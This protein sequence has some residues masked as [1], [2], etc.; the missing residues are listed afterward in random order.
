MSGVDELIEEL[1]S[2]D[3]EARAGA[4][5]ELGKCR[6]KRAVPALIERLK[7][8]DVTV[9]WRAAEALG[10][11]GDASAVPALIKTLKD[12]N[13]DVRKAATRA[14]GVMED[15]S[16]VPYLIG[17]L[18]DKDR[19]V[20]FKVRWALGRIVDKCKTT[21]DFEKVEKGIDEGSAVLRKGRVDKGILIDAQIKIA[22]LT[23]KIAKKKDELAPKRD[24]LLTDKP[25]PPKKGRGVYQTARM[26]RNG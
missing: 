23:R 11:I 14:L 19:M 9:R 24:L 25:K 16:A 26:I 7:D 3:A 1:K 2:E 12:E 15:L 8:E 4:A 10:K 17:A 5:I 20:R 22:E 13:R 18:K 21:E 6:I